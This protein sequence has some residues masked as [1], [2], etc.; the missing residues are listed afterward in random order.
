MIT[1]TILLLMV[2]ILTVITIVGIS[3]VG[4]IGVVL[5]GDLIVCILLIM[6][7][8]KKLFKR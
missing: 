6:W 8:I 5:F 1:F 4:S 3:V 7:I 2:L